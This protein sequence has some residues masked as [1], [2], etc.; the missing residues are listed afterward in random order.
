MTG[1]NL[2]ILAV[3]TLNDIR[4]RSNP[5]TSS[6]F[7]FVGFTLKNSHTQNMLLHI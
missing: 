5:E 2:A 6:F 3:V 1:P 4:K 7:L